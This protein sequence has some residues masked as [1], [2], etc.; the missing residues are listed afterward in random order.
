MTEAT[1]TWSI[2]QGM[3]NAFAGCFTRRGFPGFADRITA[4]AAGPLGSF[5]A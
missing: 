3:L 1:R 5:A 2:W 4:M